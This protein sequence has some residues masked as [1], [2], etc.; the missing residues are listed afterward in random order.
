MATIGQYLPTPEIGWNR[1]DSPN[2]TFAFI[3]N[4]SVVNYKNLYGKYAEGSSS[5]GDKVRIKFYGTKIRIYSYGSWNKPTLPGSVGIRIDDNIFDN[6]SCKYD[7]GNGSNIGSVLVYEKI[8]LPLGQHTINITLTEE[9][10]FYL[11]C[12]DIDSTGYLIHPTLNQISDITKGTDGDCIPC[13]YT[14]LTS[15]VPG[16]FS[17]LGTCVANEIP[18]TGTPTPDGLFY[19]I[20]TDKGTWIADRV[21][22]TNISWDAL[23]SAKFIEGKIFRNN[24]IPTMTNNTL[25]RGKVTTSSIYSSV[26]DGYLAFN[27]LIDDNGW[28]SSAFPTIANKQWLGYEFIVP[29]IIKSYDI[30]ARRN[31]DAP[32]D[33][34]FEGSNDNANW[35]VLDT[36]TN[37]INWTQGEVRNFNL[38]N[39]TSYKYYR[40]NISNANGSLGYVAITELYMN[41]ITD[42]NTNNSITIR[43]MSGGCAYSDV[44]GNMS[45]TDKSLG[46]WPTNNEWDKYIVNS[47]L[48]GKITKNDDNIWHHKVLNSFA[49]ETPINNCNR[50]DN[51]IAIN[52]SRV[53]RY[54]S[55]FSYWYKSSDV[56][57][58]GGF[59]PVLLLE[60]LQNYSIINNPS[61]T[62][63]NNG[64]TL[65]ISADNITHFNNLYV[66][67]KVSIKK[68]DGSIII[69]RPYD[70][71]F[72]VVP[73]MF[74]T[75]YFNISEFSDGINTVT[76]EAMDSLGNIVNWSVDITKTNINKTLIIDGDS[77]KYINNNSL[78]LLNSNYSSITED[79]L[80]ILFLSKGMNKRIELNTNFKNEV[81]NINNLKLA[82]LNTNVL[83]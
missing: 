16:Y 13:R 20:K 25:P 53:V 46:A 33:W 61:K 49:K 8:D 51:Y 35:I 18:I 5:I 57:T 24:I 66:K 78:E 54:F 68:P 63:L 45:L 43:S 72:N 81:T 1:F 21:I 14:A 9:L 17:E 82:I 50:G 42:I 47:D 31:N 83:N 48:K 37:Q 30:I 22:Q 36:Q 41:M 32:K 27:N 34:T 11:D 58:S 2:N 38:I 15:G 4:W 52:T 77:V 79:E 6:F 12:I 55:S 44:N 67:Y 70:A 23:N 26:F 76:I 64:L 28:V 60:S 56:S 59:R 39:T 62:V 73:F 65:K 10:K 29:T 69:K 75:L 7:P 19:F 40:V 74:D 71:Y 80:V 3:G